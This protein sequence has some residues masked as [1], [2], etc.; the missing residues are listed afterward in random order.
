MD[1]FFFQLEKQISISMKE[2]K[3]VILELLKQQQ[4]SMEQMQEMCLNQK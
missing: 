4:Q 3:T 1:F 2:F